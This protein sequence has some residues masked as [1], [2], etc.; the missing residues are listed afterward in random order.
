M[1]HICS[2]W[3]SLSK[4]TFDVNLSATCF[5]PSFLSSLVGT[6][7]RLDSDSILKLCLSHTATLFLSFVL[8]ASS[9]LALLSSLMMFPV[10]AFPLN[11]YWPLS[12]WS[13]HFPMSGGLLCL[14]THEPPGHPP[15]G[16][17]LYSA[18]TGT[19]GC[20]SDVF[21]L[22]VWGLQTVSRAYK[23]ELCSLRAL[24]FFAS[25]VHSASK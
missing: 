24:C 23:L 2:R 25:L 6:N 1:S 18:A 19:P 17:H 3:T 10:S 20:P 12:F 21:F 15:S 8:S 11:L 5:L 14:F 7:F 13:I 4:W 16:S 22:S 9:L